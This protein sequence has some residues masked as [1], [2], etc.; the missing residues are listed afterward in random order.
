MLLSIVSLFSLGPSEACLSP[1]PMTLPWTMCDFV[2][3]TSETFIL[4]THRRSHYPRGI[5]Q[6]KVHSH[7]FLARMQAHR[8][9]TA[10]GRL[11]APL[12][13]IPGRHMN[14]H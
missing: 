6:S 14:A 1:P 2:D 5:V 10:G 12:C 13:G 8:M 7:W 4:L 3:V 11:P 9:C